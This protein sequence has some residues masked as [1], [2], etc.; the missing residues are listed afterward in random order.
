MFP[1]PEGTCD[2][3]LID[4]ESEDLMDQVE[5]YYNYGPCILYQQE[6]GYTLS[7]EVYDTTLD[8]CFYNGQR[9]IIGSESVEELHIV[10]LS[11]SFRG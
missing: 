6:D 1:F 3:S 2:L 5:A 7:N 4:C 10:A 11:Y 9:F 8:Y